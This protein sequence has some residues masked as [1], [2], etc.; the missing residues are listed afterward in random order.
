[1]RKSTDIFIVDSEKTAISYFEVDVKIAPEDMSFKYVDQIY[2][3]SKQKNLVYEFKD[4]I[5]GN[6]LG[7]F[8]RQFEID[9]RN[10]NSTNFGVCLKK[11]FELVELLKSGK[12]SLFVIV[13]D[14]K[15]SPFYPTFNGLKKISTTSIL[16]CVET[17]LRN[18]LGLESDKI[19]IL[20]NGNITI[21]NSH[22][23][24][25]QF[26]PTFAILNISEIRIC[27]AKPLTYDPPMIEIEHVNLMNDTLN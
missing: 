24:S 19:F 9:A 26:S 23:K 10:L 17:E 13:N 20:K 22:I 18:F 27:I 25:L 15:D 2:S 16:Q 8:P 1:M 12:K 5:F 21:T 11:S 3:E 14:E 4:G 6:R 7:I